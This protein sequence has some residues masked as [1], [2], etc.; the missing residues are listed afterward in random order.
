MSMH[1]GGS[2]GPSPEQAPLT[3]GTG[4][5]P[6]MMGGNKGCAHAAAPYIFPWTFMWFGAAICVMVGSCIS[7]VQEILSLEWVDAL[8][9]AYFFFF[10]LLL[11]IVDTP[12]FTSMS[13][14]THVRQACN[15][16]VAI[17]TR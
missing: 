11:A 14:V 2:Q 13:F 17:L 16:F 7:C 6:G 15:R 1:Y 3:G 4:G 10:G 12:L 9:M 5:H 8:E